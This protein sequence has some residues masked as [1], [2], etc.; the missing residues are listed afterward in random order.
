MAP[1]ESSPHPEYRHPLQRFQKLMPHRV[2]R[3]LLVASRYDSFLLGEDVGLNDLILSE[4]LDLNLGTTPWLSRV[5]T[6]ERALAA[7][8]NRQFDLV[9]MTYHI[10]DMDIQAL[11]QQLKRIHPHLPVVPLAFDDQ[12]LREMR[13]YAQEGLFERPFVWQGDFRL[14][15]AIMQSLEDRWN[16]DHDCQRV[17][18]SSVILIE[19]SEHYYSSFLPM[20]YSEVLKQ[21]QR[22]VSEGVNL[23]NKVMRLRARPKILHCTSYEEAER[24]YRRY[25]G[26]VL[27]VISDVNF[28]KDGKMHR[29]A[30]LDFA[31]MARRDNPDLPILLQTN[32]VSLKDRATELEVKVVLKRS[33]RLLHELSVFI[34]LNF[35]FGD[36]VFRLDDGTEVG[37]V[38]D[39]GELEEMLGKVPDESILRHARRNHFSTWLRARTEFSLAEDLRHRKATEFASTTEIRRYLI[40]AIHEFRRER[41]SQIVTKFNPGDFL[42]KSGLSRIGDGSLGG[43]ARGLAFVRSI[44]SNYRVRSRFPSVE[45]GVPGGIVLATDVFDEFVDSNGLRDFALDED[46]DEVIE[47]RFLEARFPDLVFRN[48]CAFLDLADFPLAVRSSSLLED[49]QYMSFTGVYETVMI[50]NCH[51]DRSV[52][53]RQ[54]TNAI[55]R[56][57][58][59]TFS[60]RAKDYIT[61]T[62]YRLEEEKM[63]VIIQRLV[64]KRRGQRFYPDFSGVARSYNFYPVAPMKPEEGIVNVAVGLGEAVVEGGKSVAFCPLYPQ[65]PIHFSTPEAILDH[66]QSEFYALDM[67]D[68][69]VRDDPAA[70]LQLTRLGIDAAMKDGALDP[71]GSTYC[72]ESHAVYDGLGREGVPVI[73]FAPILKHE[74][75]P[76]PEVTQILLDVGSRS[77]NRPVELE[78]AVN[79]SKNPSEPSEFAFLQMRPFVLSHQTEDVDLDDYPRDQ[80]VCSS[81]LVLGGG[82]FDEIR[83]VVVVDPDRFDRG[84][85][86]EVARQVANLNAQLV[87]ARKPYLLIGVGRWGA[88]DPWLGIP[89]HWEQIAG[90]KVIVE[91][92]FK[93]FDVAPSQGS[94]FFQNITTSGVGYFTIHHTDGHGFVDWD[95]LSQEPASTDDPPLRHLELQ[96]PLAVK[97][98]GRKGCGVIL[99][100]DAPG[101]QSS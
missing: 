4:F 88:S 7:A 17:G 63:A 30:G 81:D 94:H 91:S 70:A 41:Q 57:Y 51:H 62:P 40:D 3:L 78:F 35:G 55:K 5:S 39:L 14:L 79:L 1:E 93:D 89:I 99:K 82:R 72:P 44:L 85:S 18:L 64:G 20:L 48:L 42:L 77:M 37:R 23:Q 24:Y 15:L 9:L 67:N 66:A 98:D 90:A 28:P 21:S 16:V 87:R 59:S 80:V 86:T 74:V 32:D 68:P 61:P 56:V 69:N 54:L 22:V 46:D 96:G 92:S 100:P 6:G 73:T 29:E 84:Q 43:K 25:K 38:K 26:Y 76:L 95:W 31:R 47:Q 11:A 13:V 50:P 53:I 75:F 27:G 49:S 45:I 33:R 36:F 58:A 34:H 60:Q 101:S 2:R 97:I 12:E 65:H 8:R 83:D 52:R 10:R 71:F 19:D